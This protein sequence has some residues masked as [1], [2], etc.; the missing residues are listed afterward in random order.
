MN[1]RY[2]PLV[3]SVGSNAAVARRYTGKTN[4]QRRPNRLALFGL[5]SCMTTSAVLSNRRA[6][7]RSPLR[8][9]CVVCGQFQFR[10][11]SILFFLRSLLL[12]SFLIHLSLASARVNH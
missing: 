1:F 3:T 8:P 10:C 6:T 5:G 7:S 2:S 11:L 12:E 4:A 9:L